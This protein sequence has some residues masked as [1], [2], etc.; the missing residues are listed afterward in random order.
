MSR[1]PTSP[2]ANLIIVAAATLLFIADRLRIRRGK[3]LNEND[4]CARCGALLLEP[5]GRVTIGGGPYAAWRGVVCSKCYAYVKVQE[6]IVWSL[7]AVLL[8]AV[9]V[10]AWW[11]KQQ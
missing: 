8:V 11:V 10:F 7:L 3:N 2:L 4:R 9:L 5:G 1:H 6:R